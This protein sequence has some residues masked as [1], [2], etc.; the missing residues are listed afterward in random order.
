MRASAIGT[1]LHR[2]ETINIPSTNQLQHIPS[3]Y[4]SR[5]TLYP[6]RLFFAHWCYRFEHHLFNC[7]IDSSGFRTVS[8]SL[9]LRRHFD[10]L[11]LPD[12]FTRHCQRLSNTLT[13]STSLLLFICVLS[14]HRLYILDLGLVASSQPTSHTSRYI[15]RPT[16]LDQPD[17]V[18]SSN[19][20]SFYHVTVSQMSYALLSD[21]LICF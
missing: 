18:H 16:S 7:I 21:W 10:R 5:S 6:Q 2:D 11:P 9:T 15:L 4:S 13:L 12:T 20:L 17:S 3:S 1:H 8:S 14:K 19:K